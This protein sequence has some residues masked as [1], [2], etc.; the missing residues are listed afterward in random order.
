MEKKKKKQKSNLSL[1][2]SL[3]VQFIFSVRKA[4]NGGK[5]NSADRRFCQTYTHQI[6]ELEAVHSYLL[7]WTWDTNLTFAY[8]KENKAPFLFAQS[9]S[10]HTLNKSRKQGHWQNGDRLFIVAPFLDNYHLSAHLRGTS[11]YHSCVLKLTIGV[12]IKYGCKWTAQKTRWDYSDRKNIKEERNHL[13]SL[14]TNSESQTFCSKD[15]ITQ[16][17]VCS[18]RLY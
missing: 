7:R 14:Q 11:D 4:L 15:L 5:L 6:R 2:Q 18:F 8:L 9:P 1:T 3:L 16:T 10:S 13:I 12:L 17:T